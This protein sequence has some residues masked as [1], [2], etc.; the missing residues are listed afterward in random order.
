M[1]TLRE[2]G[3]RIRGLIHKSRRDADL[4]DEVAA[5]LDC[6]AEE[7]VRR[8]MSAQ[9]ARDAA[10]RDFGAVE[11]IKETYRERRGLPMLETLI[12]DLRFG[13]RTLR[14][15]PGFTFV[16]I[17][18]LAL[19]IGANTAIFS[20]VNALLL[21]PLRYRQ[22]DRLVMVWENLR[23]GNNPQN[24]ISPANFL[25]WQ[26]HN[27]SFEQM[28]AMYDD[29]LNL[30]GDGDPEQIPYKGVSPNFFSLLGVDP[31]LGQTFSAENGVPGKDQV[32]ILSFGL[33]QRKFG[34]DRSIIGKSIQI[35]AHPYTVI[36]VMPRGF[37][38]FVKEG[39]FTGEQS[40]MWLPIAF[41]ARS[42][43][44]RG[45]YMAAIARLK[46]D[47]SLAQAQSQMD[48]LASALEKQW[49]V[50][51]KDWGINLV[52]IREQFVGNFRQALL[53]LLG[54]VAF[55][56]LIGCTNVANLL[57]ARAAQRQREIA[58]RAAMGAGRKRI[59][60]QLITE[61][62]LLAGFGGA[63]GLVLAV[64]GSRVLFA[65]GPKDMLGQNSVT[66]DWRV[67]TF[68][69]VVSLATG[70]IFG[71]GPS[72]VS[73]S[74]NVNADLK[75][76]GRDSSG[77]AR[78]NRMRSALLVLETGLALVLLVG[79]GLCVRSFYLLV[80]V[81][82]GFA[83][84][85]LLTMKLSLPAAS[86]PTDEKRI[87]FYRQL[88]QRTDAL[89]GVHA[90]SADSWL[91]FTTLGAATDFQIVGRA[92]PAVSDMP[93]TD[94]RIVEPDYFRTMGIPLFAGREF[95]DRESTSISHVVIIN[96]ALATTFFPN[97]DPIGKLLLI[98]MKDPKEQAPTEIIGV[99]GNV[100]HEGLNTTPRAMVYW[101]HPELALPFM[102][103][104]VRT[105]ANPLSLVGA[106]R[107]QVKSLDPTLPVSD[108]ATM[109]QRMADSVA[110]TRFSTLLLSLFAAL[111]IV[112]A[113]VGIYGVTSYG[114]TART[115]EIG[116]RMAL[117]AQPGD[118][119]RMFLGQGLRSSLLG[120]SLGLIAS[121][122]LTR[123]LASLLFHVS[124]YDPATFIA[125][126]ILL[127]TVA[128]FAS[129]IPARRATQVDPL[130]ALR[131]E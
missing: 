94:V 113:S 35:D 77:S 131:H 41:T 54:A 125:M 115:H 59:A 70:V 88:I 102:T 46:P 17:L 33:W 39:S 20:V 3:S 13:S 87:A 98:D 96:Q 101:P 58:I 7:N 25:Q 122:A 74:S 86:Y 34:G 36:G 24:N 95:N 27:T 55:I 30:T 103:L 90:A 120:L 71:L 117:G 44:P 64:W 82:P 51:D 129:Y 23:T 19:G 60:R 63:F 128:S 37:Q 118:V 73:I 84:Q 28:A 67:L 18:T 15:N 57:L 83:P 8:G 89:P 99:V 49:P 62:I 50:F 68:T 114:V 121:L 100:K 105:D 93:V 40:E 61:S 111:A 130:V 79:S 22:A 66:L 116:L 80:A 127:C 45:R 47:V 56:L 52:P 14:K 9:D 11:Q 92:T 69:M 48:A 1:T 107:Q 65:L 43:V 26:D 12:Q 29:H 76:G 16:A 85:N 124:P 81:N 126:A 38:L 91:P 53:V 109:E 10:R 72:L 31:F 4:N 123:F 32:A 75:E 119:Q 108:I 42:R 110:Q 106:V 112:L 78:G 97:E 104:V 21:T 6:L 2:L 5:H